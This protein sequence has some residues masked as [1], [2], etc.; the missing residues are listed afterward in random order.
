MAVNM[1]SRNLLPYAKAPPDLVTSNGDVCFA[2]EPAV[3][4]GP[5]ENSSAFCLVSCGLARGLPQLKVVLP[6]CRVSSCVVGRS[7]ACGL[8]TSPGLLL[9]TA[10]REAGHSWVVFMSS[11]Q[12]AGSV[13]LLHTVARSRSLRLAPVGDVGPIIMG[14]CPR[15]CMAVLKP[16]PLDGRPRMHLREVRRPLGV[17]ALVSGWHV[18]RRLPW[19]RTM[20]P[21]QCLRAPFLHILSCTCP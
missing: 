3:C 8:S 21:P 1:C 20:A 5:S 19:L 6:V 18:A 10:A 14:G 17:H 4:A 16:T 15:G 9:D 12:K 11:A 7:T 13:C 2:D